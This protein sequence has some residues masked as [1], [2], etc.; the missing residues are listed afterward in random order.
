MSTW[1][2]KLV[3]RGDA[4][5]LVKFTP[6]SV[7]PTKLFV[8][9]PVCQLPLPKH[10]C[11]YLLLIMPLGQFCGSCVAV[12]LYWLF[13]WLID[14]WLLWLLT[15]QHSYRLYKLRRTTI[16]RLHCSRQASTRHSRPAQLYRWELS[17]GEH[18]L[19][20]SLQVS[21][22]VSGSYYALPT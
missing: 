15:E 19:P 9:P 8:Q 7:R 17:T 13:Y 12:F 22:S 2:G 6:V 5:V 4:V 20:V 21:K 11:S 14:Y 1:S 16:S 18:W 10:F 3:D